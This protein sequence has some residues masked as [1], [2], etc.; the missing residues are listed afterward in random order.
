[1]KINNISDVSEIT[2]Q[3]FFVAG[4]VVALPT[5]ATLRKL[6][7]YTRGGELDLTDVI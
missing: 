7:I 2:F 1:M 6:N 3:T 5:T 4:R